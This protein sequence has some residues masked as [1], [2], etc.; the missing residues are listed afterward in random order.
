V[1]ITADLVTADEAELLL[2]LWQLY[3]K[4]L[5]EFRKSV[6]Q[7]DGR[8]RDDRL[9]TYLAYDE[10]FPFLIRSQGEIVG[11]ALVRKSKPDTHLIGEFFIKSQFRRSGIGVSAV[12][13]ILHK[14]AGNWEIPFQEG[15]VRGA[16]FWRKTIPQLGYQVNE[17]RVPVSD[18]P[19][20]PHEVQLSFTVTDVK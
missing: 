1:S 13:E 4:D 20:L 5:A 6:V 10:H 19:D 8:F 7:T 2:N 9:R 15:N 18:M 12:A 3:M 17:A 16:I 11:F 14:F